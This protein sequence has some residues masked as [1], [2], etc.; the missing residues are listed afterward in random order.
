M[1]L[2]HKKGKSVLASYEVEAIF[3]K[4]KRQLYSPIDL[5]ILTQEEQIS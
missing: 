4:C 1:S 2:F 5:D 3:K